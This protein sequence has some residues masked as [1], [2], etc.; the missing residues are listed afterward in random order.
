MTTKEW[1]EKNPWRTERP[2]WN[3][4]EERMTPRELPEGYVIDGFDSLPGENAERYKKYLTYRDMGPGRKIGVL[5]DQLGL[6][7]GTVRQIAARERWKER[8]AAFDRFI[9][10]E[11]QKAIRQAM[12]KHAAQMVS[13][14]MEIQEQEWQNQL[15]IQKKT[16]LMLSWPTFTHKTS[17]D[18]KTIVYTPY[19]WNATSLAQLMQLA[20]DLARRSTEMPTTYTQ[21]DI[22]A[23][24]SQEIATAH[25]TPEEKAAHEYAEREAAQLYLQK[26]EEF[27]AGK[28]TE[29]PALTAR[30]AEPEPPTWYQ[31]VDG[32]PA[33]PEPE[34]VEKP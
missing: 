8:L 5:A 18:G 7:S 28:V 9:F 3:T 20:S 19:K 33:K 29:T 2:K 13:R 26:R 6:E 10:E 24:T 14:R 34:P 12:E 23:T 30:I 22:N 27:L 32:M 15:K 11:E 21:M 17:R 16:D 25:M 1:L 31:E 4:Y